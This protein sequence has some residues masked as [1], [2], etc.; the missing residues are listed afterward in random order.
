MAKKFGDKDGYI[1]AVIN[2]RGIKD[3]FQEVTS[4]TKNGVT[5]VAAYYRSLLRNPSEYNDTMH[6]LIV[7]KAGLFKK[8]FI[9]VTEPFIRQDFLNQFK[10]AGL[11]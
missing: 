2:D 9:L 6:V 1:Y 4:L 7:E 3:R 8:K 11:L 10:Q 5:L